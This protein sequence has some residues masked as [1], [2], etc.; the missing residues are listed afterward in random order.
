MNMKINYLIILGLFYIQDTM[1]QSDFGLAPILRIDDNTLMEKFKSPPG[2]ARMSCYW[3]W[4]NSMATKESITRDLEEMKAKGYGSATLIDAGSSSYEIATKT[5]HG[6]VFMS[7]DWM[8]LYKHAVREADRLGISL[9]VNV[10][11]GWNPGG[12]SITPEHALKKLTYS[13]CNICGGKILHIKLALPES[14][15]LYRD[16]CV[17]LMYL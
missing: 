14:N 1:G 12:P 9:C 16:V 11:S 3:W 6:P 7:P 13:E 5:A 15:L 2:E 4:I 10:Q 8:G 17:P